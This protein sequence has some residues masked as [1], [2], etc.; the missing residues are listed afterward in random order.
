MPPEG[1]ALRQKVTDG[2][3]RILE[4][5][6]TNI[7]LRSE[8]VALLQL[9]GH[10]NLVKQEWI[11]EIVK[12]QQPEGSWPNLDNREADHTTILA[13]WALLGYTQNTNQPLIR[14]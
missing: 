5:P 12:A 2:I 3:V 8:A 7:D 1:E 14:H 13:L 4:D 6:A 11:M 9:S 10:K